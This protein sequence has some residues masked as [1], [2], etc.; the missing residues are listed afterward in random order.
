VGGCHGRH[1]SAIAELLL[2]GVNFQ[3]KVTVIPCPISE[4]SKSLLCYQS[5]AVRNLYLLLIPL[6]RKLEGRQAVLL[7]AHD[8]EIP[9]SSVLPVIRGR[10][11]G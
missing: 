1:G 5:Y 8:G 9:L 7:R 3:L 10:G 6:S 4:M 11:S 2:H